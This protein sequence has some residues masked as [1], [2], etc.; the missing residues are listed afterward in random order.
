LIESW[1]NTM[2]TDHA[3]DIASSLGKLQISPSS[4]AKKSAPAD[5][6]EDEADESSENETKVVS[7]PPIRPDSAQ[8]PGPPPPTPAS[9]RVQ[10]PSNAQPLPS[11]NFV[12]GTFDAPPA[13]T[14]ASRGSGPS[15]REEERRPDKTTSVAARLIAAG[16]GQKAPRRTEE[17]RKYDQAMKI[18][19]KKRRDKIKE[20]EDR[21]KRE[22]EQAKKDVWGD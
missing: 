2:S 13:A 6:W 10:S 19:E 1:N 17:Q 21:K 11:F 15:S 5:S 9:T 18:Q 12:D 14:G 7:T 3:R 16:I 22:A 8:L 20:E 4:K